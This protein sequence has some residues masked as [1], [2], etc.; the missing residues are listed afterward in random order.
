MTRPCVALMAAGAMPAVCCGRHGRDVWRPT[1]TSTN[2]KSTMTWVDVI[3]TRERRLETLDYWLSEGRAE[4]RDFSHALEDVIFAALSL[5]EVGRLQPHV[6]RINENLRL[7]V[8]DMPRW[9]SSVL[10]ELVGACIVLEELGSSAPDFRAAMRRATLK[11]PIV[12]LQREIALRESFVGKPSKSKGIPKPRTSFLKRVQEMPA[13]DALEIANCPGHPNNSPGR[14][15][16]LFLAKEIQDELRKKGEECRVQDLMQFGSRW[17]DRGRIAGWQI[18][19]M[20]ETR[21]FIWEDERLVVYHWCGF[22]RETAGLL[23]KAKGVVN[24]AQCPNLVDFKENRQAD[25]GIVSRLRDRLGTGDLRHV[26]VF[27]SGFAGLKAADLDEVPGAS[28]LDLQIADSLR[29]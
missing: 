1:L 22:F 20:G 15:L 17:R 3:S 21:V 28:K 16:T 14:P 26:L 19:Q 24:F 8:A 10:H 9:G 2:L 27:D 12:Q 23:E 7:T 29:V 4:T 11:D 25:E 6:E 13:I 18:P 5:N